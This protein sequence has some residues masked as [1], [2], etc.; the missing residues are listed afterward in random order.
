MLTAVKGRSALECIFFSH[1]PNMIT[2]EG[3]IEIR[4]ATEA[5]QGL[6]IVRGKLRDREGAKKMR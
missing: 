3:K 4:D 5:R 2:G 6:M 1:Q